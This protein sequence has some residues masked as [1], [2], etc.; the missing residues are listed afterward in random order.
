ME[1][2]VCEFNILVFF[3]V[4]HFCFGLT[5]FMLHISLGVGRGRQK[6]AAKH[7]AAKKALDQL[8]VKALTDGTVR[9]ADTVNSK[10]P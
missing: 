1:Y 3:K 6:K 7:D 2:E 4:K 9:P 5:L 8:Q 10:G